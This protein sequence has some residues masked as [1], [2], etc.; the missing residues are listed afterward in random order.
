MVLRASDFDDAGARLG[1]TLRAVLIGDVIVGPNC[2][3]GPGVSLRGDYG[4]INIGGGSNAQDNVTMHSFPG[5]E[6]RTGEDCHIGHGVVLHGCELGRNV[7]VGMNAVVMDGAE[8]GDDCFIAALAFVKGNQEVPPRSL[9][10]GIPARVVRELSDDDVA[11]K[12]R[13]TA[14]YQWLA[15]RCHQGL[16]PCEPLSEMEANRPRAEWDE[17]IRPL[18][19]KSV[20]E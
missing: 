9:L 20:D 18:H 13:G 19:D 3:I 7:L 8:I 5:A 1:A 2:Y 10:A 15:Q 14:Q 11:R 16:M 17:S 4:R 12:S 6:I